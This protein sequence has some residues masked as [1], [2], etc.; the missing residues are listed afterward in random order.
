MNS[1]GEGLEIALLTGNKNGKRKKRTQGR[2]TKYRHLVKAQQKNENIKKY[3]QGGSET[4][5]T[6]LDTLPIKN[7]KTA[8]EREG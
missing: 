4:T 6:A 5:L 1:S 3:S 8:G 2:A 7:K